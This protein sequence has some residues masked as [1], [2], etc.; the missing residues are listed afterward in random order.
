MSGMLIP[1]FSL[2]SSPGRS[3][4]M[5][6]HP[7][8]HIQRSHSTPNSLFN[9]FS[10]PT[11]STTVAPS[12]PAP[13]PAFSSH[14]S[15]TVFRFGTPAI[16]HPIL[17]TTALA[18]YQGSRIAFEATQ[19]GVEMEIEEGRRGSVHRVAGEYYYSDNQ[20]FG[21]SSSLISLP[22]HTSSSPH[23]H[24]VQDGTTT[25]LRGFVNFP[26]RFHHL[27]PK[28]DGEWNAIQWAPPEIAR[29]DFES[30]RSLVAPM[31]E[32]TGGAS[33]ILERG[34]GGAIGGREEYS[35]VRTPLSSPPK[36]TTPSLRFTDSPAIPTTSHPSFLSLLSTTIP[37]LPANQA[38]SLLPP[39]QSY[40]RP[41]ASS[42]G[43]FSDAA[44][45]ISPNIFSFRPPEIQHYP[46]EFEARMEENRLRHGAAGG[47]GGHGRKVSSG[48]YINP[49]NV[50]PFLSN[51]AALALSIDSGSNGEEEDTEDRQRFPVYPT[52][53]LH[54]I[55]RFHSTEEI[56]MGF[57]TRPIIGIDTTMRRDYTVQQ[58]TPTTNSNSIP[59]FSPVQ[60]HSPHSSP[61]HPFPPYFPSPHHT[62]TTTTTNEALRSPE[63]GG[64]ETVSSSS[65]Y[66]FGRGVSRAE[67]ADHL[68]RASVRRAERG[69][70]AE[71][72]TSGG[73][74]RKNRRDQDDSDYS[75]ADSLPS[76]SRPRV[77]SIS[78]DKDKS[79]SSKIKS[80]AHFTTRG[81]F[82]PKPTSM[83]APSLQA[84]STTTLH[85]LNSGPDLFPG[86]KS[87][88]LPTEEEFAR[89]ITKKSRGRRP[90][91]GSQGGR[92][93]AKKR[94]EDSELEGAIDSIL[95][96]EEGEMKEETGGEGLPTGEAL[97]G[98]GKKGKPRKVSVLFPLFST[99]NFSLICWWGRTIDLFAV[100]RVVS[101]IS[102]G[103]SISNDMFV[104]FIRTRNVS[105]F[106][107]SSL[108]IVS[109]S[110]ARGGRDV[111]SGS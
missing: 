51:E 24:N 80:S 109:F 22:P 82:H 84:S 97:N 92:A 52:P 19:A 11:K 102:S 62:T 35:D 8:A 69:G 49:A 10:F 77:N 79:R 106:P 16:P 32:R 41:S 26:P 96:P 91:T 40:S 60:R 104:R 89:M 58:I 61:S 99:W 43:G 54:P 23:H 105:L 17:A 48:N 4:T 9:Q 6:F 12:S 103:R 111:I 93:M 45:Q 83:L 39:T 29:H 88:G 71:S 37:H 55:S 5:S 38:R 14:D 81:I 108:R 50:S 73:G 63:R 34:F 46:L 47:G 30:T 31:M 70:T 68:A 42:S 7:P 53:P 44:D 95:P 66:T 18:N 59:F 78:H 13:S 36:S 67:E 33:S 94:K 21:H 2:T 86:T 28:Y 90:G 64:D 72:S 3:R 98:Y 76:T 1:I 100:Y 85:K 75:D 74:V 107:C 56:P 57:G 87:S 20:D 65:G 15:S 110:R 25:T 27:I 101:N